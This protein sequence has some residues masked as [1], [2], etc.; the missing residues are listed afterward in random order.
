MPN[1]NGP[2]V[3][4]ATVIVPTMFRSVQFSEE[5]TLL[6]LLRIGE[7]DGRPIAARGMLAV[8]CICWFVVVGPDS[9]SQ[10]NPHDAGA[11][12]WPSALRRSGLFAHDN[13][14]LAV[15]P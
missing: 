4:P 12:G 5:N 7:I 6:A 14:L 9:G 10:P 15:L 8:S 1:G 3:C 2:A 11:E 13:S